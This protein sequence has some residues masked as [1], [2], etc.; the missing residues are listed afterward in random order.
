MDLTV[1]MGIV[2]A[3]PNSNGN[4]VYWYVMDSIGGKLNPIVKNAQNTTKRNFVMVLLE[5]ANGL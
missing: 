3:K 1:L 2:S 5:K 4:S